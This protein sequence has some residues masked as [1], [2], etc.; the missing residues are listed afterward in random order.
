MNLLIGTWYFGPNLGQPD[1]AV[2]KSV[3]CPQVGIEFSDKVELNQSPIL[4]VRNWQK[5]ARNCQALTECSFW[6][7]STNNGE[8]FLL[9]GYGFM[10]QSEKENVTIVTGAKNCPLIDKSALNQ[11][12]SY[13]ENSR[14]WQKVSNENVNAFDQH[15]RIENVGK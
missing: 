13:S 3:R 7:W 12:P 10:V 15:M 5:C 11:C 2:Y 1:G 14:M 8:C 4:N 9:K 6:Q